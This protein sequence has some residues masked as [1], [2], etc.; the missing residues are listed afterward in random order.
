MAEIILPWYGNHSS[1]P[2]GWSRYAGIDNKFA[3]ASGAEDAGDTGGSATHT[4]TSSPHSHALNAHTHTF[5]LNS[6]SNNSNDGSNQGSPLDN[7]QDGHQHSGTSGSS[8]G[9]TGETAVTYGAVSNNPPYV[10]LIFIKSSQQVIPD[11][12]LIFWD[13]A[14][15]PTNT[16]LK[17]TDGQN[18][19]VDL[20]DKYIKA[21]DTGGDAGGTGGS[22]TNIHDISH[23][24]TS[25]SHSHSATSGSSSAERHKRDPSGTAGYMNNH[26]HSFSF[27]SANVSP[28][29]LEDTLETTET[30]EP[31]YKMLMAYQN[32]SGSNQPIPLYAIAMTIDDNLPSGWELCDG[33]NE[34]LDLRNK[35]IKITTSSENIGN[36]GGSNTHSHEAQSH[37][38]TGGTHNHTAPSQ[39][40][41]IGS[42][43]DGDNT[44]E[45]VSKTGGS[46]T[47]SVA[48]TAATFASAN[49]SA[50]TSNNQPEY[51]VVKYIQKKTASGGAA[52]FFSQMM[53]LAVFLA[54]SF[55]AFLN[56]LDT[57][58]AV[59]SGKIDTDSQVAYS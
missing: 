45:G 53:S 49:T 36:E 15:D 21:A 17:V 24:H 46:H 41:G 48:S 42:S 44:G 13:Q 54:G 10:E 57:F 22:T 1:I 33:S 27:N 31:A 38:H 30:V 32:T 39:G 34:T 19:T 58:M 11:D 3:K 25:A 6:W 28:D 8:G 12:A 4:H 23:S 7:L 5:T 43:T 50:D 52:I 20:D 9:D 51:V 47:V 35:F 59:I 56:N 37:S 2:A 14:E 16:N 29:N 55:S 26:T 18:D 40:D